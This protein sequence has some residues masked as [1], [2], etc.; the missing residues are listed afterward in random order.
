MNST[1]SIS[2]RGQGSGVR[3]HVLAVAIALI[4][5]AGCAGAPSPKTNFYSLTVEAA[6][7]RAQGS[8]GAEGGSVTRVLVSR[9]AIPGIVD[10]PQMVSRSVSMSASNSVEVFDFHRWAEP[11]QEAIPRVIAANL[12]LELGPGHAVSASLMPGLPPDVR[13]SVDVQKFEATL[14]TGV[15]VEVLWSVRPGVGEARVGRS[16]IDEPAPEAG[17][18]GIAAAYSRALAAVARDLA[19]AVSGLPA[20][21]KQ[22]RDR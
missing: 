18:A 17:H 3:R 7:A 21:Q 11:L 20:L 2:V 5:L 12:A 19:A 16:V 14:G 9:V 10:R 13:V 4:A 6:P 8:T 1:F 22:K 15:A